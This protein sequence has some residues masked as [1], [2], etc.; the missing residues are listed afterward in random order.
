MLAHAFSLI[1]AFIS[2]IYIT[3]PKVISQFS[4]VDPPRT[5]IKTVGSS[6][7]HMTKNPSTTRHQSNYLRRLA[8]AGLLK[9]L[10]S[11]QSFMRKRTRRTARAEGNERD[12]I[13]EERKNI[14]AMYMG[15]VDLLNLEGNKRRRMRTTTRKNKSKKRTKRNKSKKR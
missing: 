8:D 1:L 15:K 5:K 4:S 12:N 6:G 3:S 10:P 14:R 2:A 13:D 9:K 7:L 11:N